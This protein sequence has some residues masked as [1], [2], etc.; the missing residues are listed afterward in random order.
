MISCKD[1]LILSE[2]GLNITQIKGKLGY[3][4]NTLLGS[5][6]GLLGCLV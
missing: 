3:D 2:Q 4:R 1:G 6:K 5:C